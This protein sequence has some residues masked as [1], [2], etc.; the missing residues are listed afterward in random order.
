MNTLMRIMID[1]YVKYL[2]PTNVYGIHIR[3]HEFAGM[4][5]FVMCLCVC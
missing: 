3:V 5:H 4:D 1:F 2:L